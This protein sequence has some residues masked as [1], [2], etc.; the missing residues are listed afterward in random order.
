MPVQ[1]S[2]VFDVENSC[3]NL[4]AALERRQNGSKLMSKVGL[5]RGVREGREIIPRINPIP[6]S[7][8]S[9]FLILGSSLSTGVYNSIFQIDL[10]GNEK[11]CRIGI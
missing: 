8:V 2:S 5:K 10:A 7:G 3:F 9:I 1:I 6:S 11:A 4:R